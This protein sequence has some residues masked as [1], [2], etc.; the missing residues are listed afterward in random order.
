MQS[1]TSEQSVIPYAHP[2]ALAHSTRHLPATGRNS[3]PSYLDQSVSLYQ[4]T[5]PGTSVEPYVDVTSPMQEDDIIIARGHTKNSSPSLWTRGLLPW[6]FPARR[7]PDIEG[8]IIQIHSQEEHP[9]H[10]DIL[11]SLFRLLGDMLWTVPHAHNG[12]EHAQN[13]VFVTS[14]R[15][16]TPDGSLKDARVEGYSTGVHLS[17]GD[18]VFLWGWKRRG[19][20]RVRRGYNYTSKGTVST[21]TM[22]TSLLSLLLFLII[23]LLLFAYLRYM[24]PMLPTR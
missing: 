11:G 23:A 12:Q 19:L 6:W 5:I 15:I 22:S 14:L 10:F 21:R 20:L 2:G 3:L 17:L 16:R 1:M 4:P 9:L 8:T 7:P 13:R 24:S 18:T